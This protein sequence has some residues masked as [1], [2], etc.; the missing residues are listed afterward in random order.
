M[1]KNILILMISILFLFVTSA[2]LSAKEI[3]GTLSEGEGSSFVPFQGSAFS[4]TMDVTSG[5]YSGDYDVVIKNNNRTFYEQNN[6]IDDLYLIFNEPVGNGDI[7]KIEVNRGVF[8]F[9]MSQMETLPDVIVDALKTQMP[10]QYQKM[11]TLH[12]VE[13][14]RHKDEQKVGFFDGISQKIGSLFTHKEE[15]TKEIQEIKI[16]PTILKE[17]KDITTPIVQQSA[18]KPLISHTNIKHL[19]ETIDNV[20][21]SPHQ[22][23][24]QDT[25]V[26]GTLVSSSKIEEVAKRSKVQMPNTSVSTISTFPVAK[27]FVPVLNNK[28]APVGFKSD[29]ATA[30]DKINSFNK[31]TLPSTAGVNSKTFQT[32]I[33][34]NRVVKPN[35]QEPSFE[36]QA[37]DTKMNTPNYQPTIVSKPK[38]NE[39]K[40]PEIVK[41]PS[42]EVTEVEIKDMPIIQ[43]QK[44]KNRIIITKTIAPKDE[45]RVIKRHIE[46]KNYRKSQEQIADRMSDRVLGG[47]Y[48]DGEK[49]TIKVRA[50]SNQKAVSAWV[51]VFKAGTKQRIKTFYTGKGRSL[52]D[53]KLPAGV[54][55]IKAT[56]RT[57]SAKRQKTLGRVTLAEGQSINKKITFDDGSIKVVVKKGSKPFRAKIQIFNSS[58]SR[59]VTYSFSSRSTGVA[60]FNLATGTYDIVVKGY[61]KVKRFNEIPVS[62]SELRTVNAI[63]Q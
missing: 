10:K 51:E 29:L 59:E 3:S 54:Y 44:P 53:I 12:K 25:R 34:D 45:P 13:E 60:N 30:K 39:L 4:V 49:A 35:F 23:I 42:I 47:G 9:K 55:V 2:S 20:K 21:K 15:K 19:S 61:D 43:E 32:E 16:R 14:L 37:I 33:S 1:K 27:T 56:Y 40:Q 36:V 17:P 8:K 52:K 7:I 24:K 57:A 5:V 48:A 41:A 50:Y 18:S 6:Q 63:F 11:Q 62:A 22:S 28:Q 46:P 31:S 26:L 58:N 38:I